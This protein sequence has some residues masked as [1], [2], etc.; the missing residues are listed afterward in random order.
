MTKNRFSKQRVKILISFVLASLLLGT[1][2]AAA[3]LVS[4][5]IVDVVE[6]RVSDRSPKVTVQEVSSSFSSR[7]VPLWSSN[8]V[9]FT[10]GNVTS[11]PLIISST[12]VCSGTQITSL[13]SSVRRTYY[14]SQGLGEGRGRY[15]LAIVPDFGCI[16]EAISLIAKGVNDGGVVILENTSNG[17]VIAHELGHAL[18]LGHS[19]LV[20]CPDGKSDS[21]WGSPCNALEYGGTV[22]LM[23]NVENGDPLSTY[24][25]WRLGALNNQQIYQPWINETV[26]LYSVDA[27]SGVKAIFLRD[28][29]STYWVEFRR[30]GSSNGYRPG[31]VVYRTDPP[32]PSSIRSPN[33]GQSNA[34]QGD[35]SV[36]TDMWMMNL[37][38]FRYFNG[39]TSGSMTLSPGRSFT[40]FSGKVKISVALELGGEFIPV[41]IT[42]T[43][44]VSPPPKPMLKESK[45]W[46]GI[47]ASIIRRPYADLETDIDFFEVKSGNNTMK[48]SSN[49]STSWTPTYLNPI[50]APIDVLTSDLPEGSYQLM[51]RAVDKWGNVSPWSDS[52]SVTIDRS[53]PIVSTEFIPSELSP[54]GIKGVWKGT[55]DKGVGL[56]ESQVLND[57]GFALQRDVS[58][59]DPTFEILRSGDTNLNAQ[60]FD[61]LGNGKSVNISVK[62]N[63]IIP[64]KVRK[65]GRWVT[66]EKK[67]GITPIV[68][69]LKCTISVSVKDSYG[70]FLGKGS[71]E[72]LLSGRRVLKAQAISSDSPRLVFTSNTGKKSQILR[73]T[74]KDFTFF[75][76]AIFS[77]KFENEKPVLKTAT[78]DDASLNDLKQRDLSRIGFSAKDFA[79]PWNVV[80]IN[81]GTTLL[82]PSLDLCSAKYESES[83]RSER[84]QVTV[85]KDASPYSFLSSETVRYRNQ[86][87]ANSAYLELKE[88]SEACRLA[89]GGLD[90]RGQFISHQFLDLP[91]LEPTSQ[92][93]TKK[94]YVHVVIGSGVDARSLLGLYQF[95]EDIF[96]GIYVV[97]EG[98]DSFSEKDVSRWLQVAGVI[99]KRMTTQQG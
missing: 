17:F 74:G 72:L 85:F 22:D 78:P 31:L 89:K 14:Q 25:Q 8:G 83:F 62:S 13:L 54:L 53:L 47:D 69:K 5:K 70:V 30:F 2:P 61:C 42:R 57:E 84:R 65:T 11:N 1:L 82:D 91:R 48:V 77:S 59:S 39:K 94:I 24:H 87:A 52:Q 68:C 7:S 80:P 34:N 99:E 98:S 51:V 23:S 41:T 95:N 71:P 44:D 9:N 55:A 35:L 32:P 49:L 81:R 19:N 63:L 18:G 76:V 88:K 50:S 3:N 90:E 66:G 40:T 28:G 36:S 4:P 96:T 58:V 45:D 21:P 29:E 46:G 64:E 43:P 93:E 38:D 67:L 92:K 79:S 6:L 97:K 56:C 26:N 10:L 86:A 12:L 73:I 37:D 27:K 20:S 60:V 15:L 16:W 75:G 33:P